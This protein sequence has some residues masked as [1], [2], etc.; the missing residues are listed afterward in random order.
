MSLCPTAVDSWTLV[1]LVHTLREGVILG[2]LKPGERM[3]QGDFATRLGV[4]PTPLCEAVRLLEDDGQLIPRPPIGAV[5]AGM[6]AV[7]VEEIALMS[8]LGIS[9]E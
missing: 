7:Q 5:L 3:R 4:S 9:D 8:L 6:V 2:D 1:A